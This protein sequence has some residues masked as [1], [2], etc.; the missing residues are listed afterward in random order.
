MKTAILSLFSV[1]ICAALYVTV[2]VDL[3]HSVDDKIDEFISTTIT[4]SE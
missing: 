1:L 2:C 3:M 4:I